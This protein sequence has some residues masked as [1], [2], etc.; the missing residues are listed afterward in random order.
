[1][2]TPKSDPAD[3]SAKRRSGLLL[4]VTSL[5]SPYGIGDLGPSARAF[6]DFLAG[7]GQSLWQMLPLTPTDAACGHSPYSSASAFAGNHLLVSPEELVTD[8]LLSPGEAAQAES[9]AGSRVD[10]QAVSA[11]KQALLDKA[12]ARRKTWQLEAD[13]A[14][15]CEFNDWWLEEY[16]AFAAIKSHFR[17][18]EWG[19][20][21]R[22][23][24]LRERAALDALKARLAAP[25]ERE[26][27]VQF[28]FSRQWVRLKRYCNG[29]GVRIIGDLPIYVSYDSADAW[30]NPGILKLDGEGHP[31]V[32]A[33]VP[34]DYF[35][36]TGQLWGNPIYRW[37]VLKETGY[38]WW[39]AR[40]G[41]ALSLFDIVRV[42]HFRGFA[43]F[44]EVPATEKTA[45]NGKWVKAPAADFFRTLTGRYPNLAI[46]AEDLGLITPDVKQLMRDF[47]FPGMK[48]L[49]FAFGD[50]GATNPY[51]PHAYDTNCVVY[52]GTHDNNTV[53]GW[54]DGEAKPAEKKRLMRYLGREV[55]PDQLPWEMIRLAMMSVA[56]TAVTPLQDILGLG[57]EARMNV[58]SVLDGNWSWRCGPGQITQV[59]SDRLLEIT[60]VYGRGAAAR[61]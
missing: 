54:F 11:A 26:K 24:R 34:P 53:R 52:T 13:Y 25:I 61:P 15:F 1:M 47:A 40:M 39:C 8:G 6:A 2:T 42:D 16:A 32:V 7:S 55:A 27:F 41:H 17:N 36:K 50:D 37:D 19:S 18:T 30:S 38:H 48:V 9:P 44:W 59:V 49:L 5:P 56:E 57:Q 22:E 12:Y 33:G 29:R 4:H 31:T 46:I 28:V 14:G 45:V 3:R 23:I 35:S 21:P 51:Q 10:Y 20:W 58:P 60:E 43:G